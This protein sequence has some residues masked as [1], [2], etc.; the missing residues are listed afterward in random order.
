M[1]EPS[2]KWTPPVVSWLLLPAV[3]ATFWVLLYYPI[4]T[5]Q[6]TAPLLA[7]AFVLLLNAGVYRVTLAKW[8]KPLSGYLPSAAFG[9]IAVVTLPLTILYSWALGFAISYPGELPLNPPFVAAM[10]PVSVFATNFF[11][12]VLVLSVRTTKE[13]KMRRIFGALIFALPITYAV[14]CVLSLTTPT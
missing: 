8:L 11:G 2:R 14:I 12:S 1:S 5:A 6:G 4:L 10:L 7:G 3:L 13:V 9:I